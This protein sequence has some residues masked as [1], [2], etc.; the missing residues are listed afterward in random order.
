M[1]FILWHI[2]FFWYWCSKSISTIIALGLEVMREK[3]ILI[4][5]SLL[6]A[7]IMIIVVFCLFVFFNGHF[8]RKDSKST[9]LHPVALWTKL[10]QL[11]LKLI[12]LWWIF[13]SWTMSIKP[14]ILWQV[15]CTAILFILHRDWCFKVTGFYEY[16]WS[17][18]WQAR[19]KLFDCYG[20]VMFHNTEI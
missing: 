18:R 14:E 3:G 16:C 6:L 8:I 2:Q 7:L 17:I 4:P 11:C 10:I 5:E 1:S 13:S 19:D 12:E 20:T 9:Y 15:I